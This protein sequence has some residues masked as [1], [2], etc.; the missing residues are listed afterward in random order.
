MSLALNLHV[1][2][3]ECH[4]QIQLFSFKYDSS[5]LL[6]NAFLHMIIKIFYCCFFKSLLKLK[7]K[8]TKAVILFKVMSIYVFLLFFEHRH[9]NMFKIVD[10]F[11]IAFFTVS[12][13]IF[14]FSQTGSQLCL[15]RIFCFAIFI[16]MEKSIFF[17]PFSKGNSEKVNSS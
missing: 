1:S 6:P 13:Q 7:K 8:L 15:H 11:Q 10:W 14:F 2:F 9:D 3:S 16:R 12:K 5:C 4:K 17:H